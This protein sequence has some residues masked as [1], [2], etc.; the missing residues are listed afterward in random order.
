MHGGTLKS[1]VALVALAVVA[2]A[3]RSA[4]A[5]LLK[6]RL[7]PQEPEVEAIAGEPYGVGRWTV[8]LP[9]GVNPALLGNS[10]FTLAEKNGRAMFQAFQAEPMRTVAREFLGR[11]QTATVYFL[12][13]GE[14]PL[15]LQLYAPTAVA[16]AVTPRRDP[17]GQAKLLGDWWVK[18]A[19]QTNRIDRPADYPDLV[20][21]YLL[22]TLSRRLSLPPASQIPPPPVRQ[23]MNGLLGMAGGGQLQ[24][25]SAETGDQQL[26]QQIGLVFGTDALRSEL[27]TQVLSRRA[28]ESEFANQPLPA[29]PK[30]STNVPE[31][32]GKVAIEPIADRV[33]AE[34]FY[35]RF[36][37]FNNYLWFHDTLE[38]WGGDLKNLF[39][40]RG[41]DFGITQR[42]ERQLS[43]KQ[44][45]L[46]PLLGPAVIADVAMIGDDMFFREGAAMGMLFQARNNFG[47]NSDFIRQRSE[48]L[49]RE[50]GCADVKIDIAGHQVSLLS[51]P[52]NRV[53]SFYG[54]DGDFH[55]VTNSR[56]LMER[57]FET[58]TGKTSL[59]G[60]AEF[61]YARSLMPVDRDY[62]VFAYLSGEFF[63]NL[64][65]P[66]YQTEMLRRL[67]SASEIDMVMVAQL[68]ARAEGQKADSVEDLIKGQYLPEGFG[69]RT[70]G[71]RL[72]LNEAGEFVDSLRGARGSFTPV[73][74]IA[75]DQITPSEAKRYEQFVAWFQS[76]WSQLDPVVAGIRREPGP[77]QDQERIVLDVQLTPL[78]AKNYDTIAAALGPISKQRLA[79]VPGDVVSA[80]AVMSGNLLA[81]KGMAQPQGVYRLFGAL[82]DGEPDAVNGA[83]AAQ[84]GTPTGPQLGRGPLLNG[85]LA[86]AVLSA[87]G[88]AGG[89]GLSP[90]S[91]LPPF[92]F[93]AYPTPAI[94]SWLGVGDVPLD[95]SGYGR[96]TSGLW[97]RRVGQYTTASTDRRVLETVTP[98][99]R[100]VDAPRPAQAWLHC[101][102]LGRSKL[103]STINGLFYK[104]A[105]NAAIGNV[106]FLHELEVQLRVPMEDCLKV[107]EQ[108]TDAKLVCPLGGKYQTDERPGAFPI[109]VSTAL[110]P[111]RM[112][113]VDG[114]FEPAPADYHAPVLDWL[115]RLDA[116][117]A[118][119]QRILS[120]HGDIDMTRA[121]STAIAKLPGAPT[122]G[123]ASNTNPSNRP[124]NQSTQPSAKAPPNSQPA[125]NNP[126]PL[127]LPQPP[128]PPAPGIEELPPPKPRPSG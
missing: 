37:N 33:P 87:A 70:D 95:A 26:D 64:T 110:P 32:L 12:F 96:S 104:S 44:S 13:T 8:Q 6:G 10:M 22:A 14:G 114:L 84:S 45:V 75:F 39:N 90:L 9:Q 79:P 54:I 3:C 11:P 58:T 120:L 126:P 77:A 100:F 72:Q 1:L 38:R 118:I 102:D 124:T 119:D 63:R 78:A 5:Q 34:C 42:M 21:N 31:A 111:D 86:G 49:Q 17:V 15:E 7:R 67:R 93:G 25:P 116:D 61:R 4:N 48:T 113:L 27:Q 41:V 60:T 71:S 2:G 91:L 47:L 68:A 105:K 122:N 125:K 83:G 109:W 35:V 115:R 62:T 51:T 123:Q 127:P 73:P 57:F 99:L 65:G 50:P 43:L 56:R 80:E 88:A 112:R 107:A 46:S 53:R 29:Q 18:Y 76:K 40:R 89:G 20:N 36:G 94:F 117:V 66:H 108:L 69:T 85:P 19:R 30:F 52:D 55:F 106:R 103:A 81:S 28:A 74:D 98:Q 23:L 128:K 16:T 121:D 97:Q 24:L 101:G 82:C 92:Y 59:G